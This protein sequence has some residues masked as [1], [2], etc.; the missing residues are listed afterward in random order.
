MQALPPTGGVIMEKQKLGILT[1]LAA[2]ILWGVLGVFW[3]MLHAVPAF[4][5]L[6]YRIVWSLVTISLV[7][8]IQRAW[9]AVIQTLKELVQQKKIIHIILSSLLISI[10]WLI[11]IYLVSHGQATEASL[12][13]YIMPLMNVAVAMLFLHEHLSKTKLVSIL[14]AAIGVVIL[15]IQSG[16]L[17]LYTLLMAASFCFYGLIKK[18][19]PLPATISLFLETLFVAPIAI[20]YLFLSPHVMTQNGSH[21]TIL[22]IL[23]GIITVIPLLLFAIAAKNADFITLSFIQY[24]NPTMQLIMAVFILGEAFSP[25]K[26]IVFLFI[27]LGV[28]VFIGGSLIGYRNIQKLQRKKQ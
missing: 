25:E 23:S 18:Q 27:W 8:T 16:S 22:I 14:L 21:I 28:F 24:L 17:P 9:P 2:Y 5:I 11:Y 12:G 10:N 19:V 7:L 20:V 6:A 3:D 13:Y 4:D 15:T 1:G 26:G